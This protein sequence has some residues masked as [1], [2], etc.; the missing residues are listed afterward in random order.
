[1]IDAGTYSGFEVIRF[2]DWE[3]TMRIYA[4]STTATAA[5]AITAGTE[6]LVASLGTTDFTAIGAD[7]NEVNEVF[8][9]TTAGTGTGTCKQINVADITGY[10]PAMYISDR[11]TGEEVVEATCSITDGASGN[12]VAS[13]TETQTKDLVAGKYRYVLRLTDGNGDW[14]YLEG[15][16]TVK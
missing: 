6:Y 4:A 14:P 12:V 16:L 1:M 8:T 9:A 2:A 7:Q 10:T 11:K 3:A 13:L 5:T 15:I